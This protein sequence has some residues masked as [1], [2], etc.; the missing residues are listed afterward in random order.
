MKN[1]PHTS[2]L[3]ARQEAL[4]IVL[5][6][7]THELHREVT[8]PDGDLLIHAGDFTMFSRTAIRFGDVEPTV[9]MCLVHGVSMEDGDHSAC[10]IEIL[11]CPL[12]RTEE[13]SHPHGSLPEVGQRAEV[14]W[15]PLDFPDKLDEMLADMASSDEPR[16]GWCLLCNSPIRSDAD[17]VPGTNTHNCAEGLALEAEISTRQLEESQEQ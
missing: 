16:V 9:C 1:A 11:A 12:H 6:S 5:I 17:L 2:R 13:N 3:K 10:S 14:G 7:D 4:Q 15:V 8:V